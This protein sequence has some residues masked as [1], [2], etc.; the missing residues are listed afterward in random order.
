MGFHECS[1][2]VSPVFEGGDYTGYRIFVIHRVDAVAAASTLF[3]E[4][5]GFRIKPF[6][7]RMAL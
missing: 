7:L 1:F 4:D 6:V 2:S 5:A 3:H